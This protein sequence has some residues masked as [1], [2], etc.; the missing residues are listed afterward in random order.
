MLFN[1]WFKQSSV[2]QHGANTSQ[3]L[4]RKFI[5]DV[6][7]RGSLLHGMRQPAGVLLPT[8]VLRSRRDESTDGIYTYAYASYFLT[9]NVL[10]AFGVCLQLSN[11]QLI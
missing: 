9:S 5:N 10:T 11:M 2:G 6:I 3:Y 7:G 4:Y 1:D 8:H